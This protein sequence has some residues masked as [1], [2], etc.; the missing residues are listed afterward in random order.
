AC[1][2]VDRVPVPTIAIPQVI[3]GF[4]SFNTIIRVKAIE[5][6]ALAANRGRFLGMAS[7]FT[8]ARYFY[9]YRQDQ[10]NRKKV[11]YALA[12]SMS[13]STEDF[14]DA[15]NDSVKA[16]M[17][18]TLHKN[19]TPENSAE[20][21]DFKIYNSLGH[22]DCKGNPSDTQPPRWLS[23]IKIQPTMFY[24][25]FDCQ[26]CLYE[27]DGNFIPIPREL[28]LEPTHFGDYASDSRFKDLLDRV[29][30]DQP[31]YR[32]EHSSLGVEKD[33]WCAA[34]VGVTASTKPSL[35]FSPKDIVLT[36]QAF[37]KP[38]GGRI[39]PWF[40]KNWPRGS[41]RSTGGGFIDPLVGP[42]VGDNGVV[43]DPA[44][45]RRLPN[46]SRFPGDP[47]GLNSKKIMG[48]AKPPLITEEIYYRYYEDLWKIL[49][50]KTDSPAG[51]ILAW[52]A[53]SNRAPEGKIREMEISAM[54]PDIFDITYY[55]IE[56][57]FYENY[58]NRFKKGLDLKNTRIRSDLGAR[59][60]IEDLQKVSIMS[61]LAVA[62]STNKPTFDFENS[63]PYTVKQWQNLLT[64]WSGRDLINYVLDP[65]VFGRCDI[66]A[67]TDVSTP[68]NCVSGGRTGYSVKLVSYE[69]LSDAGSMQLGGTGG[70]QGPIINMAPPPDGW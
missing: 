58:L 64:S 59:E 5:L 66:V 8:L 11:M 62:H 49:E 20:L 53:E 68:G 35:P 43:P 40:E 1:Q 16:G 6:Q 48:A 67:K 42:R 54:I 13:E 30:L 32:F 26:G 12:K 15:D 50:N 19:L 69:T 36:A 51:D 28:Y 9:A 70:G 56:P 45:M 60:D 65:G 10:A 7:W 39:G 57:V 63:M 38:F 2:R 44:D 22:P 47:V 14:K 34:Y 41:P 21:T 25:D 55:S 17:E 61:Q 18:K 24:L 33:P 4:I 37:A 27:K 3:A 23:E 52:D 46:Y 31:F 29:Q